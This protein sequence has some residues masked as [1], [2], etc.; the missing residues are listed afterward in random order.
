MKFQCIKPEYLYIIIISYYFLLTTL[1]IRQILFFL[2]NIMHWQYFFLWKLRAQSLRRILSLSLSLSLSRALN[3][4]AS[5][6]EA[7]S[8][9]FSMQSAIDLRV[10]L[11]LLVSTSVASGSAPYPPIYRGSSQDRLISGRD[12]DLYASSNAII[13]P[14]ELEPCIPSPPLGVRAR[15]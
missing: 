8:T 9:P 11:P 10:K 3:L 13:D 4:A 14:L 1:Y 12:T 5:D 15:G 2:R 6:L 7:S